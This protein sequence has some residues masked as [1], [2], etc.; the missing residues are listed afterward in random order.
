LLHDDFTV[1]LIGF[2][3]IDGVVADLLH[4]VLLRKDPLTDR[5]LLKAAFLRVFN[6]T[7]RLSVRFELFYDWS[8]VGPGWRD[9]SWDVR[10]L[11]N[12]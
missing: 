1:V 12:V 8:E 6:Q 10:R 2:Y 3:Q 4:R 9:C 11:Q 5:S 7:S